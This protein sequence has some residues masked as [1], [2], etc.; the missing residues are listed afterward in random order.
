MDFYAEMEQLAHGL[1]RG[2]LTAHLPVA[3]EVKVDYTALSDRELSE[4]KGAFITQYLDKIRAS[5]AVL[6]ANY[7]K[8]GIAGYVGA[9]TL[10]EAA[11]A[12]ALGKLIFVLNPLGEQPC[13]PEVLGLAPTLLYGDPSAIIATA[14]ATH[15]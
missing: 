8:H 4:A 5:D 10:M 15:G 13:R 12:F 3:E 1:I 7:T 2:G 14:S 11:F 6:L 9:N